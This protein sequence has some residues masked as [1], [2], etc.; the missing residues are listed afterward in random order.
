[1]MGS[2][3]MP[4][5]PSFTIHIVVKDRIGRQASHL[6]GRS[7]EDQIRCRHNLILSFLKNLLLGYMYKM[8]KIYMVNDILLKILSMWM[9]LD[10]IEWLR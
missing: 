8:K 10:A 1:M 9:A 2:F 3:L 6:S 5:L 4:S 7:G